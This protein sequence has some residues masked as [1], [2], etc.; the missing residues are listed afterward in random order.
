MA[1]NMNVL[2][3]IFSAIAIIVAWIIPEKIKWNQMYS[4]LISEYRS[5]DFAIAVQRIIEFFVIECESDV[6][7]IPEKYRE[8]FLKE[9]YEI[10]SN[11]SIKSFYD[12]KKNYCSENYCQK[13]SD[14]TLHFQRRLLTQFYWDLDVCLKSIYIGKKRVLKDFTKGEA[15]MIR[16]LYFMNEAVDNDELLYKDLNC[17]EHVPSKSKG[18]KNSLCNLYKVLKKSNRFIEE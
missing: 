11:V 13:D 10:S 2:Q 17:F 5:Y 8:A 1:E 12:I 4:N 16:I 3:T 9:I 15:N 14:K 18:I 7:K 6:S